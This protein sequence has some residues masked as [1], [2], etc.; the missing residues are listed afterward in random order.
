M[1]LS[2]DATATAPQDTAVFP[3]SG[4][5]G[6]KSEAPRVTLAW[7]GNVRPRLL[8]KAQFFEQVRR[9]QLRSLRTGVQTALV[10]VS[11]DG[12]A[13]PLPKDLYELSKLLQGLV[14]ETDLLGWYAEDA[15]AIL[16]PDT[17]EQHARECVRRIQDH[18]A[19][20]ALAFKIVKYS[21]C[22]SLSCG[23]V[24]CPG[25]SASA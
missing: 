6:T 24:A 2:S 23:R 22:P 19:H 11:I 9:E 13:S 14:R 1:N 4:L 25:A 5:S 15:V 18:I 8:S 10:V 16:L 17:D 20:F 7:S 3:A 21:S 12:G